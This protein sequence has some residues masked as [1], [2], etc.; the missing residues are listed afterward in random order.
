MVEWSAK[1]VLDNKK[2]PWHRVC[3]REALVICGDRRRI[4]TRCPPA[5]IGRCPGASGH[6][7]DGGEAHAQLAPLT[8]VKDA[9]LSADRSV[10][11]VVH[12]NGEHIVVHLAVQPK[13]FPAP[14]H[15]TAGLQGIFQQ[16]A[17]DDTQLSIGHPLQPLGEI[18]PDVHVHALLLTPGG[19]VGDHRAHRRVFAVSPGGG[20]DGIQ[21]GGDKFLQLFR[22]GIR[23]LLDGGQLVAQV[24]ALPTQLHLMLQHQP[25]V[26]LLL[27]HL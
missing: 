3:A 23:H 27:I 22:V 13:E 8:G 5:Q 2:S 18:Q 21:Q 15:A 6:G 20:G 17:E 16:V 19:V 4:G 11:A 12:G 25:A 14:F 9:V 10:K 1:L 7:L 26:F 24:V